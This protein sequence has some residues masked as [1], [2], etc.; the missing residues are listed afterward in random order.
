MALTITVQ[1]GLTFCKAYIKQQTLFVNNQQPALGA[2]QIIL[3]TI[4]GPPF[5][6]R[7]NR[8]NFSIAISALAGTDYTV[9]LAD[10]GHIETQWMED[11]TG[12]ILQL[13]GAV[14]LAKVGTKKQPTKVAPQYDDN[15]GNITFRFD[16]VPDQNYTAYFDYQIKAPLVTGTAQ[17]LGTLP[18][19]QCHIF[20]VGL[21]AWAGMLVN[22]ARF[23]IW[24]KRFLADLLS[25]QDGL[26]DQAKM[27]FA[28][29]W[30]DLTR[31]VMRS[32]GS[33]QGG[34]AGR[35]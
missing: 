22:D 9:S 4:L 8:S 17:T 14:T 7:T 24:E 13:G 32:Q 28:G 12:K 15:L 20:F 31:T 35:S 33:T 30:M 19:E 6:W 11:G 18:D 23:P 1:D 21:L 29:Q 34:I 5:T 26:D 3:N 10:L 27:I 16:A 2:A 25:T